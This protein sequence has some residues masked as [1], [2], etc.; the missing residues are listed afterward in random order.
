MAVI[1]PF[2]GIRFNENIS[3]DLGSNIC[4]PFDAI[5]PEL[6]SSLCER[7]PY[8]IV[9]LELARE[10][11]SER[12]YDQAVITQTKWLETGVLVRDNKPSIYVTEEKFIFEGNP[13][14]RLG[15]ISAVRLEDY[16][17]KIILPHE[18]TR[19]EWVDDRVTLM[20]KVN[21]NYSPLLLL[22]RD[23]SRNTVGAIL[24]AV[25][26]GKPDAIY[27][28]ED[29]PETK[30]WRITDKGTIE[31]LSS[32]LQDSQLYIAD[33]HHRYEAALRYRGGVRSHREILSSESLNYRIMLLVSID[34]PGLITRGYHR[35]IH[36]I[37]EKQGNEILDIL[38]NK[39]IL[40]DCESNNVKSTSDFIDMLGKRAGDEVCFGIYGPQVGRFRMVKA[41]GNMRN[42]N[43]LY[44]S[45]YSWVQ[46]EIFSKTFENED[47]GKYINPVYDAEEV[48]KAVDTGKGYLG[49]LMRPTNVDE[50][51]SIVTRGWRLPA[52]ATNFFPKPPAGMVMQNLYGDL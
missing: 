21:A 39:C 20:E 40:D 6:F 7:S 44:K 10:D 29:M 12:S 18:N 24:R 19:S 48:V 9:R 31:V 42:E 36:G 8:N 49:V 43:D 51:V 32:V 13:F 50:F 26:G 41:K 16:D 28:T 37:S 15:L 35:V 3:G 5:T 38:K 45:E 30:L 27:K 22:F 47:S 52:K 25:S 4:P 33:G 34:Q 2:R 1:K 17:S 11:Y 23:D 14:S 46:R